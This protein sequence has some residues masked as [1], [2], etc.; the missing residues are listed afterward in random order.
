VAAMSAKHKLLALRLLDTC[1][2]C[3]YGQVR[4]TLFNNAYLGRLWICD[5]CHTRIGEYAVL[6]ARKRVLW[7]GPRRAKDSR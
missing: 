1:P 2:T 5:R 7:K 4:R 3:H 6:M